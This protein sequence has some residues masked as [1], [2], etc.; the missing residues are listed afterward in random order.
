[1]R[2]DTQTTM[3]KFAGITRREEMMSGTGT[4][5]EDVVEIGTI[6]MSNDMISM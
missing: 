6:N 4:A 3:Y 2:A 5:A 1:M